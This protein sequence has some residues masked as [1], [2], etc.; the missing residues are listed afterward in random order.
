M[1]RRIYTLDENVIPHDKKVIPHDKKVIDPCEK[2]QGTHDKNVKQSNIKE[3]DKEYFSLFAE[4][5][6]SYP[7]KSA[8]ASAKKAFEKLN[9]DRHLLNRILAALAWQIHSPDW[10][11]DGGQFIPYAA[12]YLNGRRWED[13]AP[14]GSCGSL[15]IDFLE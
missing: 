12:T 2:S 5:W 3:Y 13:E 11:K 6:K 9:P 4:F 1:N 7:R 14:A 15:K 10:T 8:K